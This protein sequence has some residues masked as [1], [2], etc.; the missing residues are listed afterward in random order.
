[1]LFRFVIRKWNLKTPG[2]EEDA[3]AV[4]ASTDDAAAPAATP[5]TVTATSAG[6]PADG[7]TTS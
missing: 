6:E 7:R 4:V 1:M 2:R 3:E 5:A